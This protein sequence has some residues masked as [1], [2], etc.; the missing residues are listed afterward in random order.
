[1]EEVNYSDCL[2]IVN[3]GWS[4]RW[5]LYRR[6]IELEISCTCSTGKPLEVTIDT[7]T[8][9]IQVWSVARQQLLERSQ[10]VSWLDRCFGLHA[11]RNSGELLYE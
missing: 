11:D 5:Q 7:P 1:M 8:A 9:A 6:L 2:F 10:M 4:D 3:S